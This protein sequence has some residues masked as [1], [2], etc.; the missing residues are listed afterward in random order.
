MRLRLLL[1]SL[2]ALTLAALAAVTA[3]APAAPGLSFSP[4]S[5]TINGL[6]GA[7]VELRLSDAQDVGAYEVDLSFDPAMVAVD[8]VERVIGTAAQPTPGRDWSSL[9]LSDDPNVTYDERAPGLISFGAFSLGDTAG[10]SGDVTL[11]RLHLRGAKVGTSAL[12]I[13]RALVTSTQAITDTPT[14]SA[15][16]VQVVAPVYRLYLPLLARN[17]AADLQGP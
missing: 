2:L 12:R 3:A 17:A 11:A 13:E 15:G 9:P 10:A 5:A 1:F 14:A 6:P 8:R 4:A 7:V 16:Q